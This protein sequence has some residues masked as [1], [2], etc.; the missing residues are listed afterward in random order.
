[1]PGNKRVCSNRI[2]I[3][4]RIALANIIC[5]YRVCGC[6]ISISINVGIVNPSFGTY[7]FCGMKY[8]ICTACRQAASNNPLKFS[9]NLDEALAAIDDVGT[10]GAGCEGAVSHAFAQRFT[11]KIDREGHDLCAVLRLEPCHCARCIQPA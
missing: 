2:D 7:S 9:A 11:S 8:Y 3:D 4:A 1:M 6:Y 10:A 5:T